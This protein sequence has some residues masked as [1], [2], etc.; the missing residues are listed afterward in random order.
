MTDPVTCYVGLGSNI[1]RERHINRA[2]ELLRGHY[3][4][5]LVSPVYRCPAVGF[6]GNDFYNGV[7]SFET[8]ESP[9]A[10]ARVLRGIEDQCGRDRSLP[11]FAPR[12]LDLDLLLYGDLV[13]DQDGLQIPR[14]DILEYD[15]VLRP[16]AEIAPELMH[17][18]EKRSMAD[19]WADF[20]KSNSQLKLV[21]LPA[22]APMV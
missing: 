17:P 15:F 1:E 21:C 18:E 13:R 10:I 2:L 14:S 19:L 20:D 12:T 8:T 4:Q 16:L 7:V 3:G 11:K 5:L 6:D 9:E 22:L